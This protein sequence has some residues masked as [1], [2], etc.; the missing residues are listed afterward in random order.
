MLWTVLP[1]CDVSRE[2]PLCCRGAGAVALDATDGGDVGALTEAAARMYF[3]RLAGTAATAGVGGGVDMVG[4]SAANVAALAPAAEH[5]GGLLVL[6]EGV[7]LDAQQ[8]WQIRFLRH[9]ELHAVEVCNVRPAAAILG[10]LRGS[11]SRL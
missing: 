3:Q 9:L 4:S 1:C 7:A 10:S 6:Q 8:L 2:P 11:W 5:S